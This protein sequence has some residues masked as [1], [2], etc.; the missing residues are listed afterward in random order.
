MRMGNRF[1]F[2]SIVSEN[3]EHD[4]FDDQAPKGPACDLTTQ[5]A[6]YVV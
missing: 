5:D 4:R 6:Y 1:K 2:G 3:S